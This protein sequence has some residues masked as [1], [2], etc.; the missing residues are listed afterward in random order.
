MMMIM[1]MT[2][3]CD[4]RH[5]HT[6]TQT[7]VNVKMW[8]CYAIK[9]YTQAEMLWRMGQIQLLK[10]KHTDICGNT[11]RQKCHAEGCGTWNVWLC[12]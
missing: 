6:H 4:K 7:S 3:K 9:G 12:Q 11:S 1:M 10:K 8:Q 2:D 5:T